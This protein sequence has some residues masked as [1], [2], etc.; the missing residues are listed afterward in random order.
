[1]ARFYGMTQTT[2]SWL[3]A[4]LIRKAADETKNSGFE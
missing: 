2:L 1:M 3:F 4:N